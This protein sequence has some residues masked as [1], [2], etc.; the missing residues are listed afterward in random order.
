MKLTELKKSDLSKSGIYKLSIGG[1]LYIGSS[2]IY[3]ID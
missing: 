3:I 2:K 1:H